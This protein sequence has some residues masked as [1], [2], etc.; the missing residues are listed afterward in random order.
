MSRPVRT[1]GMAVGMRHHT[2]CVDNSPRGF[3]DLA[4]HAVVKRGDVI[5]VNHYIP[6]TVRMNDGIVAEIEGNYPIEDTVRIAIVLPHP[7]QVSF[8][9]PGWCN[10]MTVRLTGG[11]PDRLAGPKQT[12]AQGRVLMDLEAGSTALSLH[13]AMPTRV[14]NRPDVGRPALPP[15]Y[16]CDGKG[17]DGALF[18]FELPN[19]SPE[20]KGLG[21]KSRALTVMR[22]PL[23]FAKSRAVGLCEK[24]IFETIAAPGAKGKETDRCGLQVSATSITPSSCWGAWNLTFECGDTRQ[25]VPACDFASAAPSDDWHNAFSIWFVSPL[26]DEEDRGDP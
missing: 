23:V 21:R 24:E 26:R 7:A 14:V 9:V 19:R 1:D 4:E 13:F 15:G 22:G 12:K 17:R 18:L 20:M 5:E 3:Y 10:E 16:E 11:T 2:C 6:M 25:I 8:R